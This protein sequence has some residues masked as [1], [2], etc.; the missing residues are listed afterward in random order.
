MN[1]RSMIGDGSKHREARRRD[2][3]AEADHSIPSGSGSSGSF[4]SSSGVRQG[5]RVWQFIPLSVH[6]I[7]PGGARYAAKTS[8]ERRFPA[9][10]LIDCKQLSRHS[11]KGEVH[12]S[13]SGGCYI[14]QVECSELNRWR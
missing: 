5:D 11:K 1:T 12:P 2:H 14:P 8:G 10:F 9:L 7:I 6:R 13:R 3:L 4:S